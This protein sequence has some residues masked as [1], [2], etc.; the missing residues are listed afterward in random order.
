[1]YIIIGRAISQRQ[2]DCWAVSRPKDSIRTRVVTVDT[3]PQNI[4]LF[5]QKH[6]LFKGFTF[7][8]HKAA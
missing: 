7:S 4:L 5:R 2:N 6:C 8:V 1:M 3:I